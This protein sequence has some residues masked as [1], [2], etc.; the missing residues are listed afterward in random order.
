MD[1]ES[2]RHHARR[3]HRHR[4]N[5]AASVA[6]A[7]RSRYPLAGRQRL[8]QNL[9]SSAILATIPTALAA[10]RPA[11]EQLVHDLSSELWPILRTSLAVSGVAVLASA[12]IGVPLGAWL[13]LT[14]V[15]GRRIV[16]VLVHSGMALPPV[17]VGLVVY[18]L[19]SRSGPLG[20]IGWL[21]T[22]SAMSV[23]QVILSLPFVVGI[24]MNAVAAVPTE[25]REQIRS[26]GAS[27]WQVR[28][29]ILREARSG[30][31]LAV[32][33]AFGRS[34]S[35]VG[36]VLMV[37]GNIRGQTRVLTTAIVLET[38]RGDFTLALT[39]SAVLLSIAWLVNFLILRFAGRSWA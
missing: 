17:V 9:E 31:L 35:E 6:N 27:P 18:L 22:P 23:A 11:G 3:A 8:C 28:W 12:L 14:A 10:R 13:G 16:S 30:V 33:S 25:L 20:S 37:G 34:W 15:R 38:A 2:V 36:A 32:A 29:T 26:L 1:F 39:L 24:T 5:E 21:F 7:R 19:L 4:Q